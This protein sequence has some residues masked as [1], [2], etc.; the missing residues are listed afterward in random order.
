MFAL[1]YYG[2]NTAE[3]DTMILIALALAAAASAPD[4]K[5]LTAEVKAADEQ[6]FA[7]I[8]QRC[9]PPALRAMLTSDFEMYHDRD[10]VVTTSADK[11]VADYAKNCAGWSKPDAWRSR[12]ALVPQSLGV[13]PVPGFGAIEQGDHEFYEHQGGRPEKKVGFAR[14]TSLWKLEDGRWKLARALSYA[15][16]PARN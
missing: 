5:A 14:F 6:L 11:F 8:F 2:N 7:L 3:V 12:R 16:G 10:G 15:H 9:D 4:T 1:L 13:W